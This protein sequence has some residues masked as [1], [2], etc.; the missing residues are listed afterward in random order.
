MPGVV[1]LQGGGPF[2]VNDDL[3]RAVLADAGIEHVVVLPTADAYEQPRLLVDQALEWGARVGVVVE[4]LMVLTRADATPEAAAV[5]A[6]APA[7]FL[8]GDSSIHLR[9]VLKGTPVFDAIREL[10]DAGGTVMACGA[11]AAALCDPMSDQRGG[12]FALGLGLIGGLAVIPSSERW[13]PEQLE[14][15]HHLATT[16]V[17]DLPTGS[18]LVRRASGWELIGGAIVHGELPAQM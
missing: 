11:S 14:R 9:S 6:G 4:P 15:A 5:I 10:L 1:V 3:D 8:A 12:G 7:V 2:N 17:V 18:A 16:P 13:P